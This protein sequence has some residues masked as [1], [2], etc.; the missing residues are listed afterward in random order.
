MATINFSI[1]SENNPT[2][3][4]C[5][6]VNGRAINLDVPMDLFVDPKHW[7][8]KQ[9][10]I[11]N[12]IVVRNRDEINRR[13]ALLKIAVHDQFNLDFS[14]GKIIDSAW[15][16]GVIKDF[17]KRPTNEAKKV[18][19]A[20]TIY[21][22]DYSHNWLKNKSAD[23]LI[24]PNKY[25]NEREVNKY[26]TFLGMVEKFQGKKK[27]IKLVDLTNDTITQF[28]NYLI[29]DDYASATVKRH[30][31]RFK[32]F[33]NRAEEDNLKINKAFKKRVFVPKDEVIKEPYLNPSEIEIAY[34][35]DFSY[36][37]RLDNVRDNLIIACWTGLRVSDFLN[38]LDISN[39]IDDFIE[40]TTQK[41]ETPV[42]IPVHPMVKRILI[43]RNGKLPHKI[44]DQKFN[45]YVKE[46]CEIVGFNSLM[47]GKLFNSEKNRGVK[48]LYKK[49]QLVSSHI[50]RRSFATNHYGKIADSVIMS[51]CGWSSKEMMLNYI[52]TSNREHAVEL[53]KYWEEIYN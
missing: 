43:K 13:L 39:F 23:W 21:Y 12:I 44:S 10:K 46:V 7:D 24:G 51:V 26:T 29:E 1:K 34:D 42:V 22:T 4:Y 31:S 36:S 33:C 45:V 50:G 40:I 28:A 15:L 30:V 20:D 16:D 53:K 19:K 8:A 3:I 48:G 37:E 38:Q 6:Y 2:K 25:M 41:T 49:S 32:F 11:R 47:K 17:F 18:N 5:R 27:K 52:K 9:Q 35:H 14:E